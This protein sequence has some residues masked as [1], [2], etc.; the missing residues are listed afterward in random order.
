MPRVPQG[1]EGCKS[2]ESLDILLKVATG[3]K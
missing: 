2:C 3:E 1:I